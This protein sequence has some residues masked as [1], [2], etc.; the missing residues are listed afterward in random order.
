LQAG[1]SAAV[2]RVSLLGGVSL[3]RADGASAAPRP[4]PGRRAELVFAYLAAEHHRAVSRD[5]LAN[6]L[7]PEL[8]PDSWA[9]ALRGVVTDVR[10]YVEE[11]GLDPAEVLISERGGYRFRLPADVVVD[12]DDGRAALTRGR[13]AL[14]QGDAAAAVGDAERALALSRL[15]FLPEHDGEWVGGLRGELDAMR[16]GA[17]ELSAHAHAQAG[18]PRAAA[19]AAAELVRIE[20]HAESGHQLRIRLLGEAGDRAGAV[21]A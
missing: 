21:R 6:A 19:R 2:R 18:E 3:D 1:V 13:A 16:L 10:R 8:L 12:L 5:E 7:W 14:E 4:L 15:P 20:P 11:A 17:L 9:A